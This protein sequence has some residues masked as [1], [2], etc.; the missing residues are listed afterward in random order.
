MACRF[1]DDAISYR[2]GRDLDMVVVVVLH[3]VKASTVVALLY[4]IQGRSIQKLNRMVPNKPKARERE[5]ELVIE[6][7]CRIP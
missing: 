6:V 1:V 5:M 7:A 2:Y 4:P 3:G